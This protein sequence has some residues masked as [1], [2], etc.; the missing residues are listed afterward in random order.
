M[1]RYI[2]CIIVLVILAVSTVLGCAHVQKN[3]VVFQSSTINALL[4]GVY[5]GDVS[6]GELK[7]NGDFG[8]GTFNALDGKMIGLEGTILSNKGGRCGISG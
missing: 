4:K 8:I 2:H 3:D 6:F 1:K 5:D 7:R